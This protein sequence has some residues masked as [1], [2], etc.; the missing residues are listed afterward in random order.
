[1]TEL[2]LASNRHPIQLYARV[3]AV[4]FLLSIVAGGFGEAYVPG[5]LIAHADAAA[6]AQNLKAAAT[7]H[8]LGFAAYLVEA[9]CDVALAWLL[10]VLLR[11][12]QRD[13]A[14][15][16]AF[17]GLVATATY[18]IGETFYFTSALALQD[19]DYLNAFTSEQ[20]NAL[21]MLSLRSFGAA[22]TLFLAFYGV[23]TVLRG[24]LIFRSGFLPKFLGVLMIIAGSG[25]I[26]KNFLYLLAPAYASNLLL[27]PIGVAAVA[28]M[29]WLFV[30]GVDVAAWDRKA[31]NAR[32][33]D[34]K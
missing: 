12:V 26:L 2:T 5:R 27:L 1:M 3:A 8:R 13:L 17:F 24:Y 19:A 7:L 21:T 6:T 14:L 23:A 20:R 15:L 18:G 34:A 25:F 33:L 9:L 31:A 16:S 22:S 10:F 11:P 4:L 28:L 30:K 29:L 32:A